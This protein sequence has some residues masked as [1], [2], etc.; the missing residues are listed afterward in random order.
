M[1]KILLTFVFSIFVFALF[2]QKSNT[3]YDFPIKPGTEEWQKIKSGDEIAMV[4]SIP[5]SILTSLTTEALAKTCLNY[6]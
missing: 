4:C 1:N 3:P 5:D 2:A 6:P